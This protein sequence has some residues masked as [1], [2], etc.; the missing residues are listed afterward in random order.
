VS[1]GPAWRHAA[2]DSLE[3]ERFDLLVIGGGI[4][5]AGIAAIEG[6]H[7]DALCGRHPNV[8]ALLEKRGFPTN[9]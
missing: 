1:T 2:L 3:R 7:L 9:E 5:G 6:S 8:K 4:N